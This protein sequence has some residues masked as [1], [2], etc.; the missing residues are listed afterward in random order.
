MTDSPAAIPAGWYADATI[1]GMMRWWDGAAWTA[2]TAPAG[3]AGGAASAARQVLPLDRPVYSP[4]IWVIVLLP[5]VSLASLFLWTPDLHFL[6]GA[7]Y[8]SGQIDPLSL[9][10]PSYFL[11]LGLSWVVYGLGVFFAYRD[12]AWLGRQGVE[13]RFH[14]AFT[15]LGWIVYVI[16]RTVM[17]RR[18]AA[19]RGLA[20][21][22]AMIGVMVIGVIVGISWTVTLTAQI[23]NQIGPG[24]GA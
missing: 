17:V 15:F 4:F 6:G 11:L 5:L 22:W 10:T 21:I 12:W 3:G 19:P 13:R 20:P 1:P 14:W 16:G 8:V 18:V 9:Y 7:G 23:V 24:V 2:H